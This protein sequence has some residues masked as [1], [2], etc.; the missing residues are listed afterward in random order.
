VL[1]GAK[2]RCPNCKKIIHTLPSEQGLVETFPIA[3]HDAERMEAL[4]GSDLPVSAKSKTTS[5]DDFRVLTESNE[6]LPP[7][8]EAPKAAGPKIVL[9]HKPLVWSKSRTFFGAILLAIVALAGFAFVRWY[10]TPRFCSTNPRTTRDR[11]AQQAYKRWLAGSPP[12]RP[13]PRGSW[14]S[15]SEWLRQQFLRTPLQQIPLL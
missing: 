5:D 13:S 14:E 2:I 9:D 7:R 10:V 1:P 6:R 3:D 4:F 15:R 8:A 11:S 12:R